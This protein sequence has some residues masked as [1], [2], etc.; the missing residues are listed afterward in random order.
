M[1]KAEM[2]GLGIVSAAAALAA[3]VALTR[4]GA[5]PRHSGRLCVTR[6]DVPAHLDAARKL[7]RSSALLALSVLADSGMEHYRGSFENRAMY[8]P[9]VV[10]L[11]SF[12]A[13]VHGGMDSNPAAHH[14][15]DAIYLTAAATGMIGNGFHLYNIVKRPGGLGWD[16]LFY[17]APIGAPIAMLLSGALGAAAERL[18]DEPARNPRLYGMP[19]GRALALLASVALIGTVGEAALLHFRGAFHNPAMYAPVAIP[20]MAAAL[21]AHAALAAPQ[22]ERWFT[23]FW[24]RCTALLGFAGVGFHT[25]GVA[26]NMGGWRNWSQNIFSGP[27]LP[28]PPS[29]TALALAGLA[30]LGLREGEADD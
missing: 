21:L 9:L 7:N 26:R 28:A 5:A 13:G 8:T 10:S 22:P 15:R 2:I 11:L 4:T 17:A 25:F 16:N 14:V 24:L 12:G 27:P 20:P 6:G 19:A 23:R 1:Q 30:A 29:F 3:T 18:R